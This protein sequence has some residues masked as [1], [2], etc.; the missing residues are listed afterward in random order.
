MLHRV[1]GVAAVVLVL[2]GCDKLFP[3]E[4]DPVQAPVVP[5]TPAAPPPVAPAPPPPVTN[6]PTIVNREA[7]GNLAPTRPPMGCIAEDAVDASMNPVDLYMSLAACV[8]EERYDSGPL[9][10]MTAGVFSRFDQARVADRS[11]HQAT[12]VLRVTH[13]DSLPPQKWAPLQERTQRLMAEPAGK[14]ALCTQVRA[15]GP[16]TYYPTYMIQHGMG[17]MTGSAADPIVPGFDPAT[18]W[19]RVVDAYLH[20]N[21]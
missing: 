16:P 8:T 12:R 7:G 1:K 20:C 4:G 17:V 9:L 18:E 10:L 5:V 21:E 19:P 3:R 13:V 11:A 15:L 6:Q 2:A 14:A